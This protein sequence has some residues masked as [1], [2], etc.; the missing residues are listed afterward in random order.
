MA[1]PEVNS[2]D[3][4]PRIPGRDPERARR[5]YGAEFLNAADVF[6]APA[7]VD[8]AIA[9][10]GQR[11]RAPRGACGTSRQFTRPRVGPML[12][13]WRCATTRGQALLK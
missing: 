2:A 1:D 7:I 9:E 3:A 11:E 4:R 8:A 5:H 6:L 12:S 13:A 10:R